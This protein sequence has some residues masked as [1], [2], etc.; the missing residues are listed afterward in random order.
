[1]AATP[2]ELC[3]RFREI[4]KERMQGLP[5][6]NP[7][8]DVDAVGFRPLG[9]R[10]RVGV[11]VTP[12]FVNLVVLPDG[13]EWSAHAQ[14]DTT[15][16]TLPGGRYEFTVNR[17]EVLGTFL[18]AVLLASVTDIPDNATARAIAADVMRRLFQ[19]PGDAV[20]AGSAARRVSRRELLTGVRA[21]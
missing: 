13:D 7:A 16:C 17:D 20:S 9:E 3:A 21:G 5:F 14:G 2:S 11:L 12:W 18:S 8:L 4:W 15:E 19:P 10:H 1:M 6:L